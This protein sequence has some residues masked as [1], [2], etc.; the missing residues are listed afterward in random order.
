MIKHSLLIALTALWL[1]IALGS[2]QARAE[3]VERLLALDAGMA[4][5]QALRT[6]DPKQKAVLLEQAQAKI[7]RIL[8]EFPDS[9]EA[10][11]LRADG[12]LIGVSPSILA[13]ARR[14]VRAELELAGELPPG[15]RDRCLS[16]PTMSC[17]FDLAGV[18]AR[19]VENKA[20][21]T[22]LLAKIAEARAGGGELEKALS[23]ARPLAYGQP[24]GPGPRAVTEISALQ[25]VS[26]QIDLALV[27]VRNL[28]GRA[29]R[30]QA[31]ARIAEALA[32]DGQIQAADEVA[33]SIEHHASRI[34]ATVAIALAAGSPDEAAEIADQ[35]IERARKLPN[36]Q[37]SD[38]TLE[39]IVMSLL[40]AGDHE[41]ATVATR[42]IID[43]VRLQRVGALVA[44]RLAE[45][46]GLEPAVELAR[47][48]GGASGSDALLVQLAKSRLEARD[49]GSV[50]IILQKLDA[51][52]PR[53]QLLDAL[54]AE[55]LTATQSMALVQTAREI[56]EPGQKARALAISG[57]FLAAAGDR[58][59]AQALRKE[60]LGGLGD[61]DPWQRA[62]ALL[63]VAAIETHL[64]RLDEALSILAD[65]PAGALWYDQVQGLAAALGKLGTLDPTLAA[66]DSIQD[67][68]DRDR[69]LLAGALALAKAGNVPDSLALTQ[70]IESAERRNH[71]LFGI[72]K[73][74]LE[75]SG[76]PRA[77]MSIFDQAEGLQRDD[78][79]LREFAAAQ[80]AAG[81]LL[82]AL[83]S[84]EKIQSPG[85]KA[86]VYM[87]LAQ[88]LRSPL[89]LQ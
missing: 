51:P 8:A 21:R 76:D 14:A 57:R 82:G 74:R 10:T 42:S 64:G 72:A 88:R 7:D 67:G 78:N 80:S 1:S 32:A 54:A 22:S 31:L 66:A 69:F 87:D 84:A 38:A 13:A 27:T 79:L 28:D 62:P 47:E 37:E 12:K 59:A 29:N 89:A 6:E 56:E 46:V 53:G 40:D 43:R 9:P 20:S 30:G 15:E 25:A 36:R 34:R 77:A 63:E 17:L 68:G 48:V 2:C 61:R 60:V 70:A 35:G 71:A 49:L 39:A 55:S 52:G 16:R 85:P 19:H 58:E 5:A 4:F 81:D 44:K 73:T 75:G 41:R 33:Q 45:T 26:G 24:T 50:A 18:T 11:H 83:R 23:L 86:L 3:S 65:I